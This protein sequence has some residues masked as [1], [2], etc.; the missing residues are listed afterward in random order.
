MESIP[1]DS[2]VKVLITRPNH[3]LG[4]QLLITPLIQEIN[5]QFPKCKIHLIVNGNL[6]YILL[7]NYH[8]VETIFNLP[9]KPFKNILDYLKKS[10]SLISNQ[11]DIAIVGC[12][13]SNSGKIFVKLSRAKFKIYNSGTVNLN[14]P[15]HIAKIPVY[16]IR[17]FLNP[18]EY[19]TD[20]YPKLSIKLSRQEIEKGNQLIKTLFNSNKKT[21]CIFTFA[22]GNKCLSKKWWLKFYKQLKTEFTDFN[23]LEILPFENV[24]QINFKSTHFYSKN[25]REIASVIENSIVFIGA[26]SGIMH[27]SS[28]TNTTTFG[29]FNVTNPKTYGPY[30][31][32]NIPL[33]TNSVKISEIIERIKEA[34]F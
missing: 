16:N 20:R 23:I 30:G 11:Y 10:I 8:C 27:L 1:R 7:S 5:K 13:D 18:S 14:R 19:L 6:S 31:G 26:D 22:T 15:K 3:R 17:K 33:D 2:E 24:S 12:E 9:K 29:L 21:I 25:L 34:I 28:S 32:N 4:N